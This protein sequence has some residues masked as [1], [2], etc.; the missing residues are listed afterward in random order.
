MPEDPKRALSDELLAQVAGGQSFCGY[1]EHTVKRG[2][3]LER[4]AQ[5]YHVSEQDLMELNQIRNRNLLM[6]GDILR[7]PVR[8]RG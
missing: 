3:T 2:D 7:V 5:R 1:L 6:I 8:I 4:I